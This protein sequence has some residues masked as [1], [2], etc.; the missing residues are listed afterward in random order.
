MT[1]KR[2]KKLL[3]SKGYERNSANAIVKET[4]RSG[5]PYA[6]TYEKLEAMLSVNISCAVE[7]FEN[8]IKQIQKIAVACSKAIAAFTETYHEAMKEENQ[9]VKGSVE[10]YE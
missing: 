9:P 5:K 6:E 4:I 8:A 2:F 1:Q 10:E 3:M 7:A